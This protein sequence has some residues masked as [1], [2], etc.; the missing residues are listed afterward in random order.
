VSTGRRCAPLADA[1]DAS[2]GTP[3]TRPSPPTSTPPSRPATTASAASPRRPPSTTGASLPA[4]QIAEKSMF[5]AAHRVIVELAG[6][7]AKTKQSPPASALELFGI[8]R[9]P[10]RRPQHPR[11][12]PNQGDPRR[13]PGRDRPAGDPRRTRHRLRQADPRYCSAAID[14]GEVATPAGYEGAVEGNTYAKLILPGM[15]ANVADADP[16]AYLGEWGGYAD[17]VRTGDDLEATLAPSAPASSTRPAPT[18][19]P[20]ASPRAPARPTRPS[21]R[22]TAQGAAATIAARVDPPADPP[23]PGLARGRR[24]RRPLTARHPPGP[25]PRRAPR[26]HDRSA[27]DLIVSGPR[28]R[29]RDTATH[30]I[31]AARARGADFPDADRAPRVRRVPRPRAHAAPPAA[32]RRVRPRARRAHPEHPRAPARQPRTSPRLRGRVP[33]DDA[34][35]ARR[36]GLRAPSSR[37]APPFRPAS[38]RPPRAAAPD[39]G[40]TDPG[41]HLRGARSASACA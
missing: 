21:D 3:S 23:R 18:R 20:S 32:P 27:P 24:L 4:K 13:R 2:A 11:D 36:A 28:R 12:R 1:G 7:P 41:R 39:R 31:A 6:T 29:Q 10:P 30:L 9:G 22:L 38:R 15:L 19:P 25:A 40:R 26:R 33:A 14:D 16:Q 17:L 5:R 35:L 34:T 8:D 37:P